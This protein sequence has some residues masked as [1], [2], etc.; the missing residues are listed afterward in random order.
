MTGHLPR[1]PLA[2]R[3]S[4]GA[5]ALNL[6]LGADVSAAE[7]VWERDW[8]HAFERARAE[9]KMVFVDFWASWCGPCLEMDR[10]TFPDPRISVQLSDFILLKVDVDRS[11]LAMA[12]RI[13]SFPTY[14]VFD[15]GEKERFRFSGF[16]EPEPFA[17]NSVWRGGPPR[18]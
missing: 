16:H 2:I 7:V 3:L 15:P 10:T 1:R 13:S 6:L 4:L 18:G 11:A 5:V 9:Q 14:S 12:H 8:S 17:S